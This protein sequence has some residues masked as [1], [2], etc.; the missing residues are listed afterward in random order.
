MCLFELQFAQGVCP[1]VGL[2]GHKV[3]C[4]FSFLRNLHTVLHSGCISLHSHQQY[5]QIP[6]SPHP[7]QH[8][9]FMGFLIMVVD[10]FLNVPVLFGCFTFGCTGSCCWAQAFSGCSEQGPLFITVCGLLIAVAFACC[11]A[12]ALGCSG[13]SSWCM[14]AQ[15]LCNM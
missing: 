12:Q 3:V 13:F 1:V 4:F 14:Q 15:L 2:L 7:L 6:F 5:R 11:R 9:L 8:L 10:F